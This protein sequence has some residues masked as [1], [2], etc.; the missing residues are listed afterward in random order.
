MNKIRQSHLKRKAY[1]YIRQSSL[2]QVQ[3]HQESTRRQYRLYERAL[4]L[5]WAKERIEI[6]DEDQGKSGASAQ[7]RSGFTRLVSEVAL[8]RAGGIFGLEVSRLARSCSDWYRLLEVAALSGALI[9]DEEGVYDPNHYNDR[10]LLGLKG[11]LSEAELHFLKQRMI[12]GRRTK[13]RRGEFRI[14]LPGGYVWDE[15]EGILMDP[16]ERAR[17]T[18]N[19]FFSCFERIGTARGTV[20]Y[21]EDNHLRFPRRDGWGSIKAVLNW[22]CLSPSRAVEILRNPIYAGVYSYDRNNSK[23]EDPEDVCS[24]GR[25]WLPNSH[26]GYISL[27]GY[28]CNL[29][30]LEDNR[31]YVLGMLTKGSARQGRSLLQGIVLCGVCGRRM[32]VMYARDGSSIYTCKGSSSVGRSCQHINGRHVDRLVKA[33]VLDSLTQEQFDLARVAMQKLKERHMEIERQWEKRLEA[34]RYEVDK[35][36][37]RYY[38]VEP[39]NRLVAR[40][41]E[42]EWND[43][44]EEAEHLESEYDEIR[45]SPPFTISREQ[46]HQVEALAEDIPRL[47]ETKTTTNNQR[48]KLLRLLIEDVTLCNQ[49]DPWCVTVKIHWKTGITNEHQAERVIP[50][51]HTTDPDV[52]DRIEQLYLSHTDQQVADLLNKEGYRSGYGNDFTVSCIAHIRQR[53]RFIKYQSS[54]KAKHRQH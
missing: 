53:K 15:S 51:P 23:A 45:R 38:Q 49:D 48:K 27:E 1:I 34:A 37:R 17:D 14:R 28:N 25:I 5:G 33:V 19:V 52:V 26:A 50:F 32:G 8:D 3:H 24:G 11:T 9:V 13:A 22:S 46:W 12:G 31:S 39:E 29:S 4:R 54:K 30:R 20:R 47:W 36:A 21:F 2:A 18:V 40:T 16:D 44:L 7:L 42:K 41:L 43:K 10:L 6:I 35:A